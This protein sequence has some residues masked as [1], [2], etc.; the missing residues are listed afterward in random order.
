[1]NRKFP[2]VRILINHA[3]DIGTL[4]HPQQNVFKKVSV[5][6]GSL[7]L[8]ALVAV[9]TLFP[10]FIMIACG[11]VVLSCVIVWLKAYL[12]WINLQHSTM[13]VTENN[14]P[15]IHY[16]KNIVIDLMAYSR[17]F[18]IYINSSTD[19]VSKWVSLGKR[20]SLFL[21]SGFVSSTIDRD[22]VG[23]L[24]WLISRMIALQY[25]RD[26]PWLITRFL[27]FFSYLNPLTLF[28]YNYYRKL[29]HMT[30]DRIGLAVNLSLIDAAEAIKKSLLQSE[31]HTRLNFNQIDQQQNT[32]QENLISSLQEIIRGRPKLINRF[33]NLVEYCCDKYPDFYADFEFHKKYNQDLLPRYIDIQEFS[34]A[35]DD[36]AKMLRELG[37]VAYELL[38]VDPPQDETDLI[39][40]AFLKLYR[41]RDVASELEDKITRLKKIKTD[42]M[43][44]GKSIALAQQKQENAKQKLQEY[45]TEIGQTS[46]T[47]L[48]NEIAEDTK[49]QSIFHKALQYQDVMIDR[50]NEMTRLDGMA[51]NILAKPKQ[52]IEISALRKQ[53]MQDTK[54][55]QIAAGDAGED[56][57]RSS[58]DQYEHDELEPIKLRITGVIAELDRRRA[59][60]EKLAIQKH[61]L[62]EELNQ[63][64]VEVTTDPESDV[65]I[66]IEQLKN[67]ARSAN[68]M[69]PRLQQNLGKVYWQN[70]KEYHEQVSEVATR[71][72][73]L[74]KRMLEFEMD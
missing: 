7:N 15:E 45:Y 41:N 8:M 67:Q 42:W 72:D 3:V 40:K 49:L 25:T 73:N 11:I 63:E 70:Q 46:F 6:L 17:P 16:I 48:K 14:F 65:P 19:I 43:A 64:G 33:V 23:Q 55:Q 68:A 62:H 44:N 5:F 69:R 54:R 35:K 61:R 47:C 30:A 31:L 66:F 58:A 2:P 60:L 13:K 37:K 12:S 74:K 52:Q 28:C 59:E 1:M 27:L 22:H 53:N 50:E 38:A 21:Q 20:R 36:E 18:D 34:E 56:F 29:T 26:N 9:A 4:F 24:V 51:G 32:L 57:W 39:N 71:L 10:E